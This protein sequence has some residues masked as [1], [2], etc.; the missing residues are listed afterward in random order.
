MNES[1]RDELLA[2]IDE[3]LINLTDNDIPEIKAQL[4]TLNGS[5]DATEIKCTELEGKI[6]INRILIGVV[7]LAG[8]GGG[9]VGIAKLIELF[10]TIGG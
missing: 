7:A 1:E 4:K 10:N 8:V 5:V 3:R 2:R 9:S 6:K